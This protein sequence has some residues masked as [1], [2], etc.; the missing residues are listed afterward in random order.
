MINFNNYVAYYYN[1]PE[2]V[3]VKARCVTDAMTEGHAARPELELSHCIVAI[4]DN[5][6]QTFTEYAAKYGIS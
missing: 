5:S 1:S 4:R 3:A 2:K 6:V